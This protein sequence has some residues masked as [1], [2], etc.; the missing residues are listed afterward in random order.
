MKI[1]VGEIRSVILGLRPDT[2]LEIKDDKISIL[3]RKSQVG[4]NANCRI[5]KDECL[6]MK[7]EGN[8]YAIIGRHFGVSRQ[9]VYEFMK[10]L[11]I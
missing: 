4:L 5:D 1:S 11:K 7:N 8:S 2:E 6:K 9:A 3:P 10:R